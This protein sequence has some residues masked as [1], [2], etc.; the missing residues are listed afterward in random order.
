M[1]KVGIIAG[2]LF[3]EAGFSENLAATT[4]KTRFGQASLLLSEHFAYI[5]R[6]GIDGS[7]HIL[8]HMINHPANMEA[9][10]ELDITEIIGIHSTGSLRRDLP[11]GTILIPD[12]FLSLSDTGTVFA[13][14]AVHITPLLDEALRQALKAAAESLGIPTVTRGTYWQTKGPRLETRA[15]I[16]MMAQFADIV[17]MTMAS[18]AVI[19]RELEMSYASI[20]SVDNYCHGI[21]E[22]PLTM[23][24]IMTGARKNAARVR[25]IVTAFVKGTTK[26]SL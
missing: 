8:P 12:D 26:E 2:T 6:H 20:C 4:V 7:R 17:G 1:K 9:F 21:T 16:R 5:P 25:E 11:P 23:Q 13:E 19:A 3:L 10:R 18:E 14:K 15:E 22:E 24:E